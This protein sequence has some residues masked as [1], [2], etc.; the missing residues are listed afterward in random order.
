MSQ[1]WMRCSS[2]STRQGRIQLLQYC[3]DGSTTTV[4][5]IAEAVY[6]EGAGPQYNTVVGPKAGLSV[7]K[8]FIL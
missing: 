7:P 6:S 4:R 8:Y 3:T 5:Y 2:S 1:N